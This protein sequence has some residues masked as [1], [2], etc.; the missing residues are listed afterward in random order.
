M[1]RAFPSSPSGIAA[2]GGAK[3]TQNHPEA[4]PLSPKQNVLKMA[5]EAS[6]HFLCHFWSP[7]EILFFPAKKIKKVA[8]FNAISS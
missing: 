5:P 6:K 7:L 4:A 3:L 2:T 8:F 1:R